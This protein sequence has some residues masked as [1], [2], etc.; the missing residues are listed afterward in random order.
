MSNTLRKLLFFLLTPVI[1]GAGG[2]AQDEY[3]EQL[4]RRAQQG[5]ASAQWQL[6]IMYYGGLA[7]R[8]ESRG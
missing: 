2:Y 1:L 4:L 8:G 7:A 6:G 3:L 5:E